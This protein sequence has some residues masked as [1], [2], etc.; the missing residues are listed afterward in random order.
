MVVTVTCYE[1][2]MANDGSDDE[3]LR[4][5][6]ALA[7]IGRRVRD[8]VRAGR[9]DGDPDRDHQVVRS[10]GGDD[11]FGVDQRAD[12]VLLDGL[13]RLGDRWP[14]SVVLEGYDETVAIGDRSGPWRYLA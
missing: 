7:E 12:E 11:V 5:A 14:G 1:R 10:E 13:A 6:A 9:P 3:L 4:L 2:P 8:V